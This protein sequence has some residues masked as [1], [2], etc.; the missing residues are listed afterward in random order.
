MSNKK[1]KKQMK[2]LM[3]LFL[4]LFLLLIMILIEFNLISKQKNEI[5]DRLISG[6]NNLNYNYYVGE[7]KV[8]V[9][10][11]LEKKVTSEFTLYNNYDSKNVQELYYDTKHIEEYSNN[12]IEDMNYY[13]MYIAPYFN[14]EK[15]DYKYMGK[16]D[17]KGNEYIVIRFMTEKK[18]EEVYIWIDPSTNLIKRIEKYKNQIVLDKRQKTFDEEYDFNIGENRLEDVQITEEELSEYSSVTN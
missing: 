12:G 11:K 7:D 13:N 8:Q 2:L 17:F 16:K 15:F 6:M 3:I 4:L 9:F 5:L 14:N 18:T 1:L 10:G